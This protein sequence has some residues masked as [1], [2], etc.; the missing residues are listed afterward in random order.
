MKSIKVLILFALCL[1][2]SLV[3]KPNIIQSCCIMSCPPLAGPEISFLA[4]QE[5]GLFSKYGLRN[6]FKLMHK[7]MVVDQLKR[8]G[9]IVSILPS[10][11]AA[12]LVFKDKNLVIFATLFKGWDYCLWAGL[13]IK[14][15]KTKLPITVAVEKGFGM[16]RLAAY[17]A[18]AKYNVDPKDVQF[19]AVPG[20]STKIYEAQKVMGAVVLPVPWKSQAEKMGLKKVY[21]LSVRE[22]E[23][24]HTVMVTTRDYLKSSPNKLKGVVST[25]KESLS[26]AKANE[27]Y[28]KSLIQKF[29]RLKDKQVINSIYN[30]YISKRMTPD[31]RPT[32]DMWI[33]FIVLVKRAGW[34]DIPPVEMLFDEEVNKQ[35]FE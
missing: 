7:N 28:M 19:K 4:A 26:F 32:K 6:D 17:E 9:E 16:D 21:D 2:F 14:N 35:L 8:G 15:L 3:L 1:V 11:L 10:T 20:I 18:F 33:N 25:F 30:F 27:E 23:I 24:P 13:S 31:I 34:P 5:K 29:Y 12:D 22:E